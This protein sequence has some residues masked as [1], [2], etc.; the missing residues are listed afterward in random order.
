MRGKKK[1]IR[2]F[3]K[4]A[5]TRPE[6]ENIRLVNPRDR[7]ELSDL[8]FLADQ[9]IPRARGICRSLLVEVS[10]IRLPIPTAGI[11]PGFRLRRMLMNLP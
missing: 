11:D 5:G 4:A 10:A 1:L 2:D 6:I 9:R 7:E 8:V 3:P